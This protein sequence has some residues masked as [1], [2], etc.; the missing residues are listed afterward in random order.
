MGLSN[1]HTSG[2]YALEWSATGSFIALAD[3]TGASGRRGETRRGKVSGFS[4]R[5]RSR[6][7]K[8][9]AKVPSDLLGRALF[10]TLTYPGAFSHDPKRWKRDLDNFRRV[11]VD[12]F[13]RIAAV[14]KLEPQKR[15]APHFH[16]LVFNVPHLPYRWLAHAWYTVVRSGDPRHL[17]AGTQVDRVRNARNALAYAGKY[18]AKVPEA[19]DMGTGEIATWDYPGRWWGV[20]NRRHLPQAIQEWTIRGQAWYQ[21]KRWLREYM[22]RKG[23]PWTFS[24]PGGGWVILPGERATKLV[25]LCRAEPLGAP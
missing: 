21:I 7:M 5:S 3:C 24:G 22:K 12:R 11:L 13:P 14:W 10:V 6:L 25:Q 16:L 15:G 20:I 18:V 23:K 2:R 1:G 8:L 19:T 17:E 4:P 9:T